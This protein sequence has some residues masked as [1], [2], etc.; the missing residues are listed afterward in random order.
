MSK[1]SSLS[2]ALKA[3]AMLYL[4]RGSVDDDEALEEEVE[5]TRL[6]LNDGNEKVC[7]CFPFKDLAMV[8]EDNE[9]DGEDDLKRALLPEDQDLAAMI[10]LMEAI[11][12]RVSIFEY[13][14]F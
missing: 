11:L 12:R 13:S 3:T 5:N 10:L 9:D 7:D 6:L 1:L 4:S 8:V 14:C 2:L